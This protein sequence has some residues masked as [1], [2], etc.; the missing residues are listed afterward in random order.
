MQQRIMNQA[1]AMIGPDASAGVKMLLEHAQARQFEATISAV[2][3]LRVVVTATAVFARLQYS[4]NR[5]FNVRTR[6]GFV[7]AWLYKRFLSL[8][9]VFGMGVAL[10]GSV[11]ASSVVSALLSGRGPVLLAVNFLV[12]LAMYALIFV[13]MFR[14][15]PDV[16]ITWEDTWVGGV[17]CAVLFLIGNYIISMYFARTATASLY[18]A[19]GS[20]VVLLLWVFYSAVA[21]FFG[22]ELTQAYGK[23]CGAEIVPNEFAEWDPLAARIREEAERRREEVRHG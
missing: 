21:I 10:V 1:V 6:Q 17:V 5:I 18:G 19:A 20:L 3:G 2:V 12:N 11:V 22:A 9:M 13:I 23:C 15:L 8:L 14:V 4:L 7:M 16:T